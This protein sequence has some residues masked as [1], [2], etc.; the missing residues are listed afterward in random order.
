MS[1]SAEAGHPDT[2]HDSRH[3]RDCEI[4]SSTCLDVSL[5]DSKLVSKQRAIE[6]TA[7]RRQ[8][9]RHTKGLTFLRF[10]LIGVAETVACVTFPYNSEIVAYDWIID[11]NVSR[12]RSSSSSVHSPYPITRPGG[13]DNVLR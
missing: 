10:A 7:T 8:C 3:V 13:P 2:E 9:I 5:A 11:A 12:P 1:A 6:D 4:A